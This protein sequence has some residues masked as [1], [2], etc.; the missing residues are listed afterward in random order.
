MGNNC[1]RPDEDYEFDQ[2]S[3]LYVDT[4]EQPRTNSR[5]GKVRGGRNM[6]D[7]YD[8]KAGLHEMPS[9]KVRLEDQEDLII[10]KHDY[11]QEELRQIVHIQSFYRWKRAKRMLK[12]RIS[13]SRR[14]VGEILEEK[15]LLVKNKQIEDFY[16]PRVKE[17][18]DHV[19]QEDSYFSHHAVPNDLRDENF[20]RVKELK[21]R[22]SIY[23]N[24]PLFYTDK[25]RNEVYQGF[26]DYDLNPHLWGIQVDE[27]GGRYEGEFDH[28]ARTGYG[29][30]I[31]SN[32]NLQHGFFTNGGLQ[33]DGV[34][35]GYQG[36][37]YVGN[38]E[39][40][41]INGD[42]AEY[43]KDGSKYIGTFV[44][45]QKTGK[46][47]FTWADGSVYEGGVQAD[48]LHGK[49]IYKWADKKCYTGDWV[50][51]M[52]EGKGVFTYPDGTS[53]EGEFHHNKRNGQGVFRWNEKRW[54]EGPWKDGRQH[55]EGVYHKEGKMVTGTWDNGKLI[56]EEEKSAR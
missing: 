31:N 36:T 41:Q 4:N 33:K 26:V 32:G 20:Y 43:F 16:A 9:I 27:K 28:G 2:S 44:N 5:T 37:I 47:K 17:I 49:G 23:L 10:T 21:T 19:H 45:G 48:L 54:Y 52:M 14:T 18:L 34:Y 6:Q 24:C 51:N 42:G 22:E 7:T 8:D 40:N 50:D 39:N 13:K 12:K 56:R 15:D 29:R 3:Q 30:Y 25:P 35:V 1:C 53:Y 55:G 46:G 38:W 11:S